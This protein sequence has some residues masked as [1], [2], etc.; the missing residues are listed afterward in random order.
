MCTVDTGLLGQ[1]WWNQ[2]FPQAF[3]DF[4]TQHVCRDFEAVRHWAESNQ[5][6]VDVPEDFLQ[7]PKRHNVLESIP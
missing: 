3:P 2:D 6:P 5:A 7:S 1:V 4:N